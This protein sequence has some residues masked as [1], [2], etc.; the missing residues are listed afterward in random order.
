MSRRP[1]TVREVVAI[2]EQIPQGDYVYV[3]P[4][5]GRRRVIDLALI[6]IDCEGRKR[7]VFRTQPAPTE[8]AT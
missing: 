1:M 3:E 8:D 6:E 5:F 4:R 2:L 7:I